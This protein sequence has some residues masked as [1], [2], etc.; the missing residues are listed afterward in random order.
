MVPGSRLLKK[1]K[2]INHREHGENT[3]RSQRNNNQAFTSVSSEITQSPLWL[4]FFLGIPQLIYQ[5]NHI[6]IPS[7]ISDST[8]R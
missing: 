8:A 6:Y 4:I 2:S 3:Q 5:Y 1:S 7:V